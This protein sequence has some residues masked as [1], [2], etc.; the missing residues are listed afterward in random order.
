LVMKTV[1]G[2]L[3]ELNDDYAS[4]RKYDTLKTPASYL[5]DVKNFYKFM[6]ERGKLG[7]QN[8]FPRVMNEH[9]AK[10]WRLFLGI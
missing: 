4:A 10:E 8:K 1:D 5:T 7:S 3:S 9:Q 2:F 6:E